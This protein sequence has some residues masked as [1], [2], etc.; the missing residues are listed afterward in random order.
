M[1]SGELCVCR[2]SPGGAASVQTQGRRDQALP[3]SQD[4]LGFAP[5]RGQAGPRARGSQEPASPPPRRAR[6]GGEQAEAQPGTSHGPAPGPGRRGGRPGSV[7]R[8][9]SHGRPLPSQVNALT[10]FVI[11]MAIVSVLNSVIANKLTVMVR[12]AAEPG[13][14]CRAGD[15]HRSFSMAIEP[16]RVQALRHG[17]RVLRT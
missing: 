12:Q 14:A 15:P 3:R 16:G 6:A 13:P 4:T 7:R 5:H 8:P 10:S 2:T 11:P 9:G 1:S 17:V